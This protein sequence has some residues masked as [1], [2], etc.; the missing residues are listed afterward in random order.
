[1]GARGFSLGTGA[2]GLGIGT[3]TGFGA[4]AAGLGTGPNG[5]EAGAAGL[6]T[7]ATGLEAGAAGLG[8]GATGLEAGAAGLRGAMGLGALGERGC[9]LTSAVF[10]RSKNAISPQYIFIL[11]L[12]SLLNG[13]PISSI[14]F[15]TT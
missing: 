12:V 4:R 3:S 10:P 7:G 6:G 2:N 11:L 5:L 9:A 13:R 8:T 15:R 14:D 1:M